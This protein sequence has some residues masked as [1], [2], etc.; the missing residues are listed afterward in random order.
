M[1][2]PVPGPAPEKASDKAPGAPFRR[3]M[4]TAKLRRDA[5]TPFRVAAEP[6]E[7]AALADFLDVDRVDRLNFAGFIAPA[8]DDGWRVRGRLVARIEQSCVVTLEPVTS[9]IESDVERLYLPDDRLPDEHEVHVVP[10]EEDTPDPYTDSL[11]P[12]Q[13]AVESLAL[14]I[15]P[16][17]RA[18]GAELGQRSFAAPGVTPLSN[19]AS[20]PFA[21]LAVLKRPAEDEED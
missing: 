8:A 3:P 12:A 19:E 17:P 1:T 5:E 6:E 15:D 14:L 16:Y 21:G 20:R 2:R 10:D 7:R 13:L 9:R 4:A 11:D 18:D